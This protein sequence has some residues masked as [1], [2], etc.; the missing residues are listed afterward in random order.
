[1]RLHGAVQRDES[2]LTSAQVTVWDADGGGDGGDVLS[3]ASLSAGPWSCRRCPH[4]NGLFNLKSGLT[5]VT[6]AQTFCMAVGE[7]SGLAGEC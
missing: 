3:F 1:M 5:T 4:A 2:R 7:P 6:K